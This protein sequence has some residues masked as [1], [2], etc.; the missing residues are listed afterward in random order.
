MRAKV[1]AVLFWFAAL[2]LFPTVVLARQNASPADLVVLHGRIYTVNAKQPWAQALAIRDGKILSVG[3]E[4]EIEKY[5]GPS[6]KVIDA[7]SHLV[8]PGFEDTHVHFTAGSFSLQQVKLDDAGSIGEIQKRV[9]EY[10]EAHPGT[11]FIQGI[12]LDVPSVW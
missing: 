11:S 3:A 12:W 7:R 6:T 10:A 5:R 9:K 2:A 4:R 1:A 8:L